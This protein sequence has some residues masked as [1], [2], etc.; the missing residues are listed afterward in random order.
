LQPTFIPL[1]TER[2]ERMVLRAA[3]VGVLLLLAV[4]ANAVDFK[5]CSIGCAPGDVGNNK[6]DI[7]CMTE[8][9]GFDAADCETTFP[10][11]AEFTE[12]LGL[13]QIQ[14]KVFYNSINRTLVRLC[15]LFTPSSS[16]LAVCSTSPPSPPPSPSQVSAFA[17]RGGRCINSF[18]SCMS[19]S[20]VCIQLRQC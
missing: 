5:G 20:L 10:R 16:V 4:A 11:K 2:T 9:C 13:H 18:A 6:C 12:Y 8:G 1:V 7:A 3:S 14:G 19:V 17:P 15:V